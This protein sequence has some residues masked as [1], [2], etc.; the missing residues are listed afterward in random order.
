MEDKRPSKTAIGA[1]LMRA[2]HL[3]LDDN[4]K[5]LEDRLALPFIGNHYEGI[6]QENRVCFQT[7]ELNF[8]RS[9]VVMRN[10]YTED[11]LEEAI[12]CNVTQYVILGAGLDSFAYRRRDLSDFLQIYEVDHPS[13]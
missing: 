8:F 12:A 13:T 11:Q 2:I 3:I 6:I 1:A 7:P 5:I 4:P 10:R 9:F